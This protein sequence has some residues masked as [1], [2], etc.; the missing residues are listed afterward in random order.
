MYSSS[1]LPNQNIT[2]EVK[3]PDTA[4]AAGVA[5]TTVTE[6]IEEKGDTI[7]LSE[8]LVSSDSPPTITTPEIFDVISTSDFV[9]AVDLGLTSWLPPS[10]LII[11]FVADVVG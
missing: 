3:S 9:S 5:D 2:F 6:D 4:N 10:K 7:D 1:F 11:I 8:F